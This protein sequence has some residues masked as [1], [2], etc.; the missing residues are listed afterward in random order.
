MGSG[1]VERAVALVFNLRLKKRGMRW[2]RGN[3]TAMVALLVQQINA[4]WEAVAAWHPIVGG[5][6]AIPRLDTVAI[7]LYSECGTDIQEQHNPEGA[8]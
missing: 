7:C 8:P 4:A 3:A 2:K 1:L 5:T 6:A